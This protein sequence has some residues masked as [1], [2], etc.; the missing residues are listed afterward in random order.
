MQTNLPDGRP[1]MRVYGY[2][3]RRMSF[4]GLEWEIC[5]RI[6]GINLAPRSENDPGRLSIVFDTSYIPYI[7]SHFDLTKYVNGIFGDNFFE[8]Y[9]LRYIYV[10]SLV[11]RRPFCFNTGHAVLIFCA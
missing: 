7:E 11:M 9:V 6:P 10:R 5:Q 8:F 4:F 3:S 2:A 1:T